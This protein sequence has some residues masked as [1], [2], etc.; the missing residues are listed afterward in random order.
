MTLV[1]PRVEANILQIKNIPNKVVLY[2]L[3]RPFGPISSCK[4]SE[5]S[6]TALL[7]YFKSENAYDAQQMMVNKISYTSLSLSLTL[8][9][10]HIYIHLIE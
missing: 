1:E 2:E 6:T 10:T 9:H 7:Q 5:G 8:I 3:F 4:I